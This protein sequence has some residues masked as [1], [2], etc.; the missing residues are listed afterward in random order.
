MNSQ[1]AQQVVRQEE[2]MNSDEWE[3]ELF[4]R[5]SK[6]LG[7]SP[8]KL[9]RECEE[10]REE[11]RR[12]YEEK[13]PAYAFGLFELLD[14]WQSTGRATLRLTKE[15]VHLIYDAFALDISLHYLPWL[16]SKLPPWP[17]ELI[18]LAGDVVLRLMTD[19]D[20]DETR[21]HMLKGLIERLSIMMRIEEQI[22]DCQTWPCVV[23]I[24]GYSLTAVSVALTM[25]Q[26]E[27]LPGWPLLELNRATKKL[28]DDTITMM[29]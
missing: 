28:V 12:E 16:P 26:M 8:E 9:R 25:Q 29:P 22:R 11:R 23:E 13:R 19:E 2:K 10:A 3:D 5:L 27:H 21:I 4:A 14:S 20:Y 18:G 7:K 15:Q 6:I 1:E 17:P 24:D